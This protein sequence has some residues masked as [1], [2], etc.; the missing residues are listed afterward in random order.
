MSKSLDLPEFRTGTHKDRLLAPVSGYYRGKSTIAGATVPVQAVLPFCASSRDG[1]FFLVKNSKA[2]CTSLAHA[3]FTYDT[4]RRFDGN[5]HREGNHLRQGYGHWQENLALLD[6]ASPYV[7]SA[8]R[9]PVDR[10]VSAF[11]DFVIEGRNPSV[12]HHHSGFEAAGL[13]RPD[14]PSRRFDRFLEFVERELAE[15]G[16]KADR[17]WRLQTRNLWMERINFDILMRIGELATGIARLCRETGIAPERMPVRHSNRSAVSDG[18]V[19]TDAQRRRIE[20]MYSADFE[21]F[22]CAV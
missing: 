14:D 10:L 20:A 18:Y 1:K 8:V 21:V 13:F 16:W 3:L 4:G 6:D 22:E 9:H 2:G 5:I 7:F 11:R 17:H 12:R 19:P 15:K